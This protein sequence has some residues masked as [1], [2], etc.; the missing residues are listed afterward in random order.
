MMWVWVELY[1]ICGYSAVLVLFA[2]GTVFPYILI[3][4]IAENQL[5]TNIRL[6]FWTPNYILLVMS[7]V[8][9]LKPFCPELWNLVLSFEIRVCDQIGS[10]KRVFWLFYTPHIYHLKFFIIDFC[11]GKCLELWWPCCYVLESCSL[12]CTALI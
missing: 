9:M 3:S 11:T 7:F 4:L 8:L 5:A 1:F 10:S 6:H 2:E 12:N